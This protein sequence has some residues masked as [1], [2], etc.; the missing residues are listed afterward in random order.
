MHSL[1]VYH[2]GCKAIDFFWE[3]I[4]SDLKEDLE[5]YIHTHPSA[6]LEK[7]GEPIRQTFQATCLLHDV[8]HSPFSHTGEAFYE[9]GATFT[10]E[11]EKAADMTLDE[12]GNT[13]EEP[14]SP[15]KQ[16]YEDMKIRRKGTGNP[17]EVMSALVG[18]SL[19]RQINI[20]IDFDLFTRSIIG[21][22]YDS[23]GSPLDTV[24]LNAVIGMLN[25][26]LI[27]VGKLDYIERD[28][29]MTGYSSL[30]L[31][32]DR[33]LSSY[34][35]GELPSGRQGPIYKK[36]ALSII[37]SEMRSHVKET[38]P[39]LNTVFTRQAISAEG[40]SELNHQLKLL[41]DDDIV[42]YIKNEDN[43]EIS[44]QYFSR[45]QRLRPLWKTETEFEDL[46][47]KNLTPEIQKLLVSDLESMREYIRKNGQLFINEKLIETL[48]KDIEQA[49]A[50][51]KVWIQKIPMQ[52]QYK[53]NAT[54]L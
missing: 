44:Q 35:V 1:G 10:E 19:Y 15:A 39:K 24:I 37:E 51:K 17:H 2:L 45:R 48:D 53:I 26:L 33:L 54:N 18:L 52:K 20:N 29:Y 42:C 6:D 31:D 41:C 22:Q 34:T 23:D 11:L 16:L 49:E 21:V 50:R 4:K 8:G 28:S 12:K 25:G 47:N 38:K 13:S 14:P 30:A 3:N 27:D 46:A 43:S 36:S 7:D 9:K 5:K 32:T 40:T